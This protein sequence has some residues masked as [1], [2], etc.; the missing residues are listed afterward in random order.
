MEDKVEAV[1][2]CYRT[3]MIRINI[4]LRRRI[5]RNIL[6]HNNIRTR[7]ITFDTGATA[8]AAAQVVV[9]PVVTMLIFY[10]H[11]HKRF[12]FIPILRNFSIILI[13]TDHQCLLPIYLWSVHNMHRF[14]RITGEIQAVTTTT[15]IHILIII[16]SSSILDMEV[17]VTTTTEEER[18]KVKKMMMMMRTTKRTKKMRI[19]KDK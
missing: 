7:T 1:T 13:I 9:L 10:K 18:K 16:S 3:D 4:I 6:I 11:P 2:W 17:P 19:N 5:M 14:G 8:A 15:T 12:P